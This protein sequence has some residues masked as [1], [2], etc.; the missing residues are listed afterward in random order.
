MRE[1]VIIG[2]L[3]E[4]SPQTTANTQ[5]LWSFG[6]PII[7]KNTTRFRAN[8]FGFYALNGNSVIDFRGRS[9]KED[10]CEFLREIRRMNPVRWIIIILDNFSSHR[11][12]DTIQC[13]AE[14]GI[15]LVYLPPY[16]P[17]LN[18]LEYIWKSIRR[19]ISRTF[20]SNIDHMKKLIR[21]NFQDFSS[22]L[23]FAR[24]WIERFL[25]GEIKYEILGSQL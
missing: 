23:S 1:D 22:Q 12:R 5:R 10:V 21:D 13:A 11:A 9:K 6:K 2:F 15:E 14:C 3:D 4:S 7:Y 16:S 24:G 17:D 25:N 20:I 19:V 18:P 8:T